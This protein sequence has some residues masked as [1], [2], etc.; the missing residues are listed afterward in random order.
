MTDRTGD[1]IPDVF[2]PDDV[3]ARFVISM[4]MARND[5]ER[6][7]RDAESAIENNRPDFSYRAR[8]AIGHL[9]E[10][11]DALDA[12]SQRE[13]VRALMRRVPAEA[14]DHLKTARGSL[15]RPGRVCYRTLDTT[16]STIRRRARTTRLRQTTS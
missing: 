8:L 6:A 1:A 5:I 11:L 13:E 12:Y 7:L 10:G 3:T 14:A 16:S 2:P 4:A 9:V 15:Q